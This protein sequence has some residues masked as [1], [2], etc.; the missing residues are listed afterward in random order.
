ANGHGVTGHRTVSVAHIFLIQ[1]FFKVT[2]KICE[3]NEPG[4]VEYS[5]GEYKT[6][7]NQQKQDDLRSHKDSMANMNVPLN[8]N[9]ILHPQLGSSF[10]GVQDV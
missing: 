10:I 4:D 2:A 7:V 9:V 6:S 3:G 5:E 1:M 8:L